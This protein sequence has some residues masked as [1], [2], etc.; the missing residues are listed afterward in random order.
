MVSA[1]ATIVATVGGVGLIAFLLWAAK[2]GHGDRDAEEAARDFFTAHG[3]W[4]D[5][6]PPAADV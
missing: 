3:H 4:P 5:E 6:P 2:S 1:V